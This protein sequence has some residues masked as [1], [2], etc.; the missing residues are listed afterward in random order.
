MGLVSLEVVVEELER[1]M[2]VDLE[3]SMRDQD[4]RVGGVGIGCFFFGVGESQV[5]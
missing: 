2:G 1:G 4:V 3:T 5:G